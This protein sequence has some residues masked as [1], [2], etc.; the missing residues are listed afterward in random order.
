LNQ[1]YG[2]GVIVLFVK[3]SKAAKIQD[4]MTKLKGFG[5]GK[6][7]SD[8]YWRALIKILTRDDYLKEESYASGFGSAVKLTSKGFSHL[9]KHSSS[10]TPLPLPLKL[11]SEFLDASKEETGLK[12]GKT[13]SASR[14]ERVDILPPDVFYDDDDNDGYLNGGWE[15]RDLSYKNA[16]KKSSQE[17]NETSQQSQQDAGMVEKLYQVL[18]AARYNISKEADLPP[19]RV[20]SNATLS[21]MATKRPT[22]M[23]DLANIRDLPDTKALKFGPKFIE[24]IKKFCVENNLPIT[25][26]PER[27]SSENY[28]DLSETVAESYRKF[29]AHQMSVEKIATERKFAVTTI[30]GHLATAVE[31]GYPIDVERLGL[32]S[33]VKATIEKAIRDPPIN[34]DVTKLKP[35]KEVLPEEIS[36]GQIK[37]TIALLK[38]KL[39]QKRSISP[40]QAAG[41]MTKKIKLNL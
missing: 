6:S 36:Y 2:A 38:T 40:S 26:E 4:W 3:G 15:P 21:D 39:H 23:A 37:L 18:L 25:A 33:R 30:E 34:S 1:K 35:I 19:V 24:C 28:P 10:S 5:G 9:R 14:T 7:H 32:T 41:G 22:T 16:S 12:T 8:K 31:L 13:S 11:T 27:G 17:I 20:A 29:H